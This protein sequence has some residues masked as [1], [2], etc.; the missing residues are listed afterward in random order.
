MGKPAKLRKLALQ[1]KT[2]PSITFYH[3]VTGRVI[4]TKTKPE[5]HRELFSEQRGTLYTVDGKEELRKDIK[6]PDYETAVV[7]MVT[8]KLGFTIEKPNFGHWIDPNYWTPLCINP[9]QEVKD[10]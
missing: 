7:Y 10:G 3:P 1:D 6:F 4:P 8:R 5:L 9:A 2:R